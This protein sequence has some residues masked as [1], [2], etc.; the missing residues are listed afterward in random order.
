MKSYRASII[1]AVLAGACFY[2]TFR[3]GQRSERKITWLSELTMKT[4]GRKIYLVDMVVTCANGKQLGPLQV[5]LNLRNG[6]LRIVRNDN[7]LEP[8]CDPA[9]K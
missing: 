1:A 7:K 2:A 9:V 5:D 3:L 6:S 8:N 4:Q